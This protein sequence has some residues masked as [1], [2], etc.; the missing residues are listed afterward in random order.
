M[1]LIWKL[2][3]DK[4]VKPTIKFKSCLRHNLLIYVVILEQEKDL[5][6]LRAILLFIKVE[7][8]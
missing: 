5:N 6:V 1:G 4:Y 2:S 3:V 7:L 8:T